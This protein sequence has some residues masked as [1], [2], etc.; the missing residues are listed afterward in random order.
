[1]SIVFSAPLGDGITVIV[2]IENVPSM[3]HLKPYQRELLT[4]YVRILVD[5]GIP[6]GV[7]GQP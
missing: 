5:S 7:E 6:S 4:D 1:M 3:R 2:Q